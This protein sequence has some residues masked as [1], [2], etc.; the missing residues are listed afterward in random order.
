VVRIGGLVDAPTELGIAS[1]LERERPLG[2]H[3]MECSGNGDFARFGMLSAAE[4][5]GVPLAELLAEH[6]RAL[7]SATRVRISGND[8]HSQPSA[9]ST[10]GASWV[11]SFDELAGTKAFLATAMNGVP[12][13][14][15]HGAPVRLLVPGWYGCT[16]IKWVDAIDLVADDEPATSQMIE[17]ASRTMQDGTPAL[18]RDYRAASIDQ[19]AMP[20]RVERWNVDGAIL[21]RIVGVMW[22]GSAPTDGLAIRIDNGAPERVRVCP[23]QATNATWTWW[24]HAWRPPHPG[25]YAM[26]MLVLASKS[27][28]RRLDSGFYARRITI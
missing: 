21:H 16:C 13:P 23:P 11:L 28:T 18:A 6:V 3:L 10:R 22:G 19:A 26:N 20:V 8:D 12:L 14:P 7:P 15:D 9:N 17:F 27:P 24:T 2:V 5:S 1:L 25:T 4:W